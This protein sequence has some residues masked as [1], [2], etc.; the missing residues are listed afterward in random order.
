M[1]DGKG[2]EVMAFKADSTGPH[3]SDD[4]AETDEE[5]VYS[6]KY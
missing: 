5:I 4:G 6:R 1:D 3:F 2:E